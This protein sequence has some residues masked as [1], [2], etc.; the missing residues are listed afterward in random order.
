[1]VRSVGPAP[2]RPGTFR[3]HEADLSRQSHRTHAHH[4]RQ[5]HHRQHVPVEISMPEAWRDE[6]A[7][8]HVPVHRLVMWNSEAAIG[9]TSELVSS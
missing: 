5:R 1:M 7:G 8:D 3:R 9:S 6:R 2:A 4:H